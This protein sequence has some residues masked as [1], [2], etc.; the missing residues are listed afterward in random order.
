MQMNDAG[1][2]FQKMMP[3]NDADEFLKIV[4]NELHRII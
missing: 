2:F 4:Q 1:E 3:M